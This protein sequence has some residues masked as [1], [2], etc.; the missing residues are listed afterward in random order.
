MNGSF[1]HSNWQSLSTLSILYVED[2]DDIRPQLELFLSRW[3]GNLFTATN[4]KEGLEKYEAHR[5]DLVITDIQMPVM[6][7]LAMAEAIKQR[8]PTT[9]I[10]VTTAYSDHGYFLRAFDIGVDKYV[11][12]PVNTD[13]LLAALADSARPL[14]Q[15][16]EIEQKNREL[17][18][19]AAKLQAYHDHAEEEMHITLY[20]MK[21]MTRAEGLQDTQLRYWQIPA[22]RFSG[23]LICAARSGD[24]SLYIFLADATGHGLPAAVN[25]L[26]LNRIFYRMVEKGFTVSRIVEEMNTR[27]KQ[28]SPPD[29]FVAA[30]LMR[31]CNVNRTIDLWNG[32]N[33]D[34][35]FLDSG[36]VPLHRFTSR[37]APLGILGPEAFEP[38]TEIYQWPSAG[39]L[40]VC[41]DGLVEA[42]NSNGTQITMEGLTAAMRGQKDFFAT[43]VMLVKQHLDGGAAHD[44]LSLATIHCPQTLLSEKQK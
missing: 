36:G 8:S 28:Q 43:A 6:D 3:A 12:K 30:T 20:L 38:H 33:P 18:E 2:D 24:D 16:R 29:R 22:Q 35:L 17:A 11:L 14:L 44:D 10:L 7:G 26:W 42:E 4:G 31:I 27:V 9:P 41:S 5:P 15:R 21:R 19:Q 1:D 34:G 39:D 23:D 25:L 37:Y 32:G 40:L 13:V